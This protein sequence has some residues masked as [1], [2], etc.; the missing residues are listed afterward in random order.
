LSAA[1]AAWIFRYGSAIDSS[2][3]DTP[4]SETTRSAEAMM[5]AISFTMLS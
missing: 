5:P 1:S 2:G 3:S 4:L